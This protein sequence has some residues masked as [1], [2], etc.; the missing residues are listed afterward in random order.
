MRNRSS[1]RIVVGIVLLSALTTVGV[2]RASAEAFIVKDGTPRAS[3]VIAEKPTRMQKLAAEQLREYIQKITGAALPIGSTPGSE[4]Q[5]TV[6][7]GQSE[8]T[9]KLG[10]KTDDLDHGA[11][12]IK[13]GDDWLALIGKDT[14]Y[15]MDKPGD[16]GPEYAARNSDRKRAVDAW[17]EKNGP[18]WHHAADTHWYYNHEL[19]VWT[20]D[21]HG[22]LNAVNDFLRS[23]GV[24]W[25]MPG[26]FGEVCP[27][28]TSI[29][30]PEI[31]KTV[32]SEWKQREMIFWRNRPHQTT[33]DNVLWQLRLGMHVDPKVWGIHGTDNLIVPEW[34]KQNHPEY[35]ALYGGERETRDKGKP[36]YSSEGLFESA[37]N[38][39]KLMFDEYGKDVVTLTPS[40]A[41]S[42]ICQCDLCR[43]KDTPE[44]G[45]RGLMSDYVWDFMNRVAA[46]VAKT[47]PD[48]K[49]R[50]HAY[51]S[52]RK[53]PLNIETFHPNLQVSICQSRHAFHNPEVREEFMSIREAYIEKL[54]AGR[55]GLFEYYS[56]RDGIPRYY[57]H[58]IAEDMQALRG[59]IEGSYI[60]VSGGEIAG[61]R[62][63]PDPTLATRH[64]HLWLTGRL[65][66][67]PDPAGL[68]WTD[69]ENVDDMLDEY[70]TNFYGPAGD[71]MRTFIDY[72]EK[73]WPL[74][75]SKPEVIDMIFELITA[76]RK[77]AGSEGIYADRVQLVIDYM[78]PLKR[79]RE[80]L[81]VGRT[82]NP[83]AVFNEVDEND[84][85][86][87]GKLD[88]AFWETTS[89]Y[90]LKHIVTGED[91][92]HGTTFKVVWSEDS[93]YFGVRCEEPDMD[94]LTVPARA[95]GDL[96]LFDGDSIEILLETPSHAYYQIAI[97]PE[98]H[99][100]D[101][102]RP[103]SIIIG[104]TGKYRTIW[105]A[106]ATVATHQG[107][108]FWSVEARIPA[109]GANQEKILPDFGV[110]GDKPSKDMPWHF[111]VCR[112]RKVG[113]D[114]RQYS[115]FS[116][117]GEH[118]FHYMRGFAKLEPQ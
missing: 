10:L 51:G 116:P 106:G 9:E 58:M 32:R 69:A 98:G 71:E 26:E 47:H 23:L 28:M 86:L 103:N 91:V 66:W 107:K 94:K 96:T 5:L 33:G 56:S 72:A 88:E 81:E 76:A 46:E 12:R 38:F 63:G 92:E 1:S 24:R 13:S 85:E 48:K 53:P 54:P 62:E 57:P 39:S 90:E 25:Y 110:S 40:D 82:D 78:E 115:T 34:V 52:Y 113:M 30:L 22:S 101:L 41:F 117:T 44:R 8:H 31:D 50:C 4:M 79:I 111:N 61:R 73:K 102:D 83:V 37:V 27:T 20:T 89:T 59:H 3:I 36:C 60:E 87:D 104:K 49:I 55:L 35:Y 105:E 18:Q 93:L 42:A 7:V 16:A 15:F 68:W 74:T 19:D 65:W 112:S 64:L 70:C 2:S 99:V 84:I 77:A 14:N 80:Q 67:S 95:S 118:G 29:P 21:D 97:D 75:R 114:K 17:R 43:G 100:N 11:Y 108:T 109:M 6:Y 45:L